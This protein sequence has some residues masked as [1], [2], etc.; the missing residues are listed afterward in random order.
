MPLLSSEKKAEAGAYGC[1]QAP[2]CCEEDRRAWDIE[3]NLD[4]GQQEPDDVTARMCRNRLC[5]QAEC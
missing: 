4:S 3:A 5:E 2:T 1:L